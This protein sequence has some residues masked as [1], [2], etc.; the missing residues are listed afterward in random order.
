MI[1]QIRKK[2]RLD[3]AHPIHV[4]PL[5]RTQFDSEFHVKPERRHRYLD[6]RILLLSRFCRDRGIDGSIW[7]NSRRH[8]AFLQAICGGG[9][10]ASLARASSSTIETTR[11]KRMKRKNNTKIK[12][13]KEKRKRKKEGKK[14]GR[15]GKEDRLV[16]RGCSRREKSTLHFSWW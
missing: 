3:I 2:S 8:S 12:K 5:T 14:K 6:S 10:R 15:K 9:T 4:Y 16:F 11:E 7:K 13:K 1:R